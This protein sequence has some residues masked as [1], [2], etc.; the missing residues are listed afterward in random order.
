M[1]F[2]ELTLSATFKQY[3]CEDTIPGKGILTWHTSVITQNWLFPWRSYWDIV[4]SQIFS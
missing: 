1:F 2:I 4:S 3:L